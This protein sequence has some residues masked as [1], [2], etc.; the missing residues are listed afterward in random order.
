MISTVNGN[1][2]D[3]SQEQAMTVD[4]HNVLAKL[5][6]VARARTEKEYMDKLGELKDSEEW[7][8]SSNLQSCMTKTWLPQYKVIYINLKLIATRET[9]AEKKRLHLISLHQALILKVYVNLSEMGL[10]ID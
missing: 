5:R 4:N 9:L 3:G 2:K 7:K 6:S 10:G 1:R 8:S